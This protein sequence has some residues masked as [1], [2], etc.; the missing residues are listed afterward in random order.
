[1]RRVLLLVREECTAREGEE[2]VES[3]PESTFTGFNWNKVNTCFLEVMIEEI[4]SIIKSKCLQW[5]GLRWLKKL[6][7][8]IQNDLTWLLSKSCTGALSL[9][10]WGAGS[11]FTC[12]TRVV[13]V[14]PRGALGA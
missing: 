9:F 14:R 13:W 4:L 11:P 3:K 5:M 2:G 8:Y 1:M 10:G 6:L 7:I 12:P